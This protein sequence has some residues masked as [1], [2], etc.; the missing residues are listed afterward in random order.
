MIYVNVFL[1]KYINKSNPKTL[2]SLIETMELI[3]TQSIFPKKSLMTVLI[4]LIFLYAS[5]PQFTL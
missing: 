5:E 4:P 2:Y 1:N 3:T